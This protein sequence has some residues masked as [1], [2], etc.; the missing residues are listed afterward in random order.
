[1]TSSLAH[2]YVAYRAHVRAK[3]ALLR[4]ESGEALAAGEARQYHALALRHLEHAR[5]RLILVGGGP[6]TGKSTVAEG[7]ARDLEQAGW[8]I[9]LR[10]RELDRRGEGR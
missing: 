1:M 6:G 5:P 8:P 9:S 10:H 4:F 3:V 7:L 2:F